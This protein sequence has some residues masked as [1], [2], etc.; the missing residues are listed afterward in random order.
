MGFFDWLFGN[1]KN[2]LGR[3]EL[4]DNQLCPQCWGYQTYDDQFR[5]MAKDHQ[6]DLANA[7]VRD[8]FVKDFINKHVTGIVLKT[9]G[10][11]LVCPKCKSGYKQVNTKAN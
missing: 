4:L 1:K 10:D 11:K 6:K 8:A 9:E 2:E 5:E 7:K 3:D